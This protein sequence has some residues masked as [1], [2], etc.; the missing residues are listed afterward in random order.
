MRAVLLID[1]G[2]TYTKL[3]AVDL[4]TPSI[5]GRSQAFTTA[6]TDISIGLQNALAALETNCGALHYEARLACSS[7]AG[8]LNMVACGLVPSLTSKAAKL[9]AFGAGAKVIK[10]FAYQ[11]T[12]GDIEDINAMKPDILLLSGGIDGGNSEVIIHNAGMLRQTKGNFPIV[13]AGNRS[14]QDDCASLLKG[15]SHPVYQADNVMPEMNKLNIEPV[16]KVIREIFLKRIILAKGLNKATSMIDG[17]LMPT[18]SAVLDALTLLSEGDKNTPGVG[19]LIAVDLGGAT[20]DV[21]SIAKG[22]PT[23]PTTVLRGLPEP[24]VKRTVEGDLGMRY[25]A[26]GIREAVGDEVLSQLCG[27]PVDAMSATVQTYHE[28]PSKLPET[29]QERA[30]DKALAAAAISTAL[31]RHAGVLEQVYTPVGPMYQQTGK[32]LTQVERLIVTGG[33]LIYSK[34]IDQIIDSALLLQEPF[35]LIPK[36]LHVSADKNYVLSAL[37]LLAG[38]EQSA[39]LNL[40][41][42][43]FG[44]EEAN[45]VV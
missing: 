1:F 29:D 40:L 44:R 11:L 35:A 20:T 39:A 34:S 25:N 5:L 3:T 23:N 10:T 42:E 14:A 19:E 16:A 4:D 28:N 15:S 24:F 9:A 32:D 12:L 43:F 31:A 18:P 6:S 36:Q 33:A 27:L 13:L 7:A 45:A 2:S 21:Y 37:G 30:I 8:G 38:Y 17:I 22:Y 26:I 41:L